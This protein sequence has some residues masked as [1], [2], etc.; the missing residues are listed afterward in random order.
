[1]ATEDLSLRIR[2]LDAKLAAVEAQRVSKEVSKIGGAAQAAGR[3]S[4]EA[5]GHFGLFS[6]ALGGF[7]FAA[8]A[9]G[10][11]GLAFGIK[12]VVTA[13][14]KLQDQQTQLRRALKDS[15]D[16]GA[17]AYE[18]INKAVEQSAGHGGFAVPEQ[19]AG[20]TRFIGLTG[21][22]TKAIELSSAATD[23]ARHLHVDYASAVSMVSRASIGAT[24]RLQQY[25]GVIQPVTA[26]VQALTAAQKKAHPELLK[27]AQ[28]L[29]KQATATEALGRIQQ[30]FGGSTVTFSHTA[31]GALSNAKNAIESLA[32]RIGV[33][34]LPLITKL[35]RMLASVAQTVQ[36]HWPA[37]MAV[38]KAVI[39]PV[40]GF[41]KAVL[42]SR[43]AVQALIAVLAPLAVLFLAYKTVSMFRNALVAVKGA[44]L[45]LGLATQVTT[46]ETLAFDTALDANPIGLIVLAIAALVA[47]LIFLV[48]HFK[49]VRKIAGEV[50]SWLK[51]AV[52]S[53]A[54]F[55]SSV[56]TGL[57]S[58][59]SKHWK[60][61]LSIL[62]G[63]FVAAGIFIATH[64]HQIGRVASDVVSAIGKVFRGLFSVLAWPFQQAWK[65]IQGI[66]NAIVS[67]FRWLVGKVKSIVSSIIGLPGKIL[68]GIGHGVS[69][70]LNALN[71]FGASGGLVHAHGFAAGGPVGPR[72]SDT[73]PAWLTPG[74]FVLRKQVTAQV[75]TEQ[76]HRLNQG[77]MVQGGATGEPGVVELHHTT[78]L[79][80]RVLAEEVVRYSLGRAARGPTSLTGGAQVG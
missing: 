7:K 42:G 54:G 74:E 3:K 5:S 67:A 20:I 44:L 4:K 65:V 46:G 8:G 55:I 28:L 37:I 45:A 33:M 78:R 72:G 49:S 79:S 16:V 52:S 75:G 19:L 26:H 1:M 18:R 15:G 10:F 56:F 32:A 50:F 73:V 59:I 68:G 36:R 62:G 30:R 13:G 63:P 2:L 66:V 69:G 53:V 24:G 14:M 39:A 35:A 61:I 12:D 40:V 11:A 58:F 43:I 17:G 57:I 70:A 38:I 23:I 29:D 21:S 6:K 60:L 76:L 34:L 31:P 64:L 25:I 51:G 47:A 80:A 77:G 27:Q 41:I 22:A 48:M 71:P 9:T